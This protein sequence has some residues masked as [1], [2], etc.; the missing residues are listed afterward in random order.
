MM[1]TLVFTGTGSLEVMERDIP[2]P[3]DGEVQIAV[4]AVSI[5]GSDL[6]AYR[7]A[8]ERF[9]PPLVLG[10]E[11]SGIISALG[12]GV[13]GL[14]EGQPVSVNP[15]LYCGECYH[16]KRGEVNLCGFRRSLGTA[17]GGVRTDGAMREYMT[18]RASAVVPLPAGLSFA[19]GAL[20]EPSG[21]CLACA[22]CGHTADEERVVVMGAGP[23]GLL[24]VKFLKS[25]GVREIIVSDVV[26]NRLQ[27]A[28]NCGATKTINVSKTD[29][30]LVIKEL[31]GGI[32]V[33][34]VII[35]AGIG[36]AIAQSFA[37]VRNGGTVVLVALIHDA[38][39]FDPMQIVGRGIKLLGSYMF[40][41]E[42]KE[43]AT[44]IAEGRLSV[45]DLVT[46]TFPLTE[47]KKAFDLLMNPQ[48]SEI[49]VQLAL[50]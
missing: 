43:A 9:A 50:D 29:P 39:E 40:T 38:V 3:A 48:N 25:L 33:D 35:A 16:C 44:L 1:K 32:G 42:M 8:T 13:T 26:E 18:V 46:S 31:T 37:L 7:H 24:T 47:G 6:G 27:A 11:L 14:R 10:H 22:K 28:A 21:V 34:R 5:C 4:K 15:I 17:I 2:L 19:D 12:K 36:G 20:L 45:R 49:K 23:I 30:T 41:T